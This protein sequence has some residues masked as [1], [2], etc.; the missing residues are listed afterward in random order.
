MTYDTNPA[1][2][3]K[4]GPEGQDCLND[5]GEDLVECCDT[6]PGV[7]CPRCP[8]PM[9]LYINVTVVG[10]TPCPRAADNS[11]MEIQCTFV[12][13]PNRTYKLRQHPANPCYYELLSPGVNVRMSVWQ[14]GIQTDYIVPI[15]K[16]G[17]QIRLF[18]GSSANYVQ[19]ETEVFGP[20][21]SGLMLLTAVSKLNGIIVMGACPSAT[22]EVLTQTSYCWP[23]EG[24]H[25]YGAQ[26]V[27]SAA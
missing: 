2:S 23:T 11:G 25:C 13:N 12:D 18:G 20:F 5:A 17:Y 6:V 27:M 24:V 8:G 15:K 14:G 16:V 7:D 9:P 19:I 4:V 21:S 10:L 22:P 1:G 3:N 26:T